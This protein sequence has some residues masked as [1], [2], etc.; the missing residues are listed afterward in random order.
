[1]LDGA[2]DERVGQEKLRAGDP[3]RE[4][5]PCPGPVLARAGVCRVVHEVGRYDGEETHRRQDG[6]GVGE[7]GE[8]VVGRFEVGDGRGHVEEKEVYGCN[9]PNGITLKEETEDYWSTR[10]RNDQYSKGGMGKRYGRH[11]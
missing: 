5:L 4:H 11:A 8:A 2:R 10:E 9:D 6:V 3:D 7:V 1:M